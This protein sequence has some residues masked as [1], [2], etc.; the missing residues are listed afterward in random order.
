[1]VLFLILFSDVTFHPDSIATNMKYTTKSIWL[2]IWKRQ[3]RH[4]NVKSVE[5]ISRKKNNHKTCAKKALSFFGSYLE[6]LTFSAYF[7]LNIK[8]KWIA[9]HFSNDSLDLYF[10]KS[11]GPCKRI[12]FSTPQC[13]CQGLLFKHSYN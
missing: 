12:Y 7:F 5:N 9:T 8:H 13:I 10:S 4:S 3:L 11:L 1:M 2:F 6:I